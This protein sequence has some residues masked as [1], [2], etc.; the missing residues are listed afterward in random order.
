MGP[1]NSHDGLSGKR[2]LVTGGAGFLGSA[3]VRELCHAGAEVTVLDNFS[4]GK[5]EYLENLTQT[6]GLKILAGDICDQGMVEKSMRD[7]ELVIHL[8]ALPFIPDSYHHPKDFFRTNVEG[9]INLLL[10]AS[11]AGTVERFVYISSSEVYGSAKSE[12]MNEDHPTLPPSTYAA[13]K[14]AADRVTF[15]MSKEGA[16]P[17]VIVRPFNCFGPN[18]TQPYIVPEI[19]GQ[20]SNGK[21][22]LWLGNVEACRDLTFVDDTARGIVLSAVAPRTV[23]EIINLGSGSAISIRELARKILSLMGKRVEI[24]KDSSRMRP[25]DVERL[26]C[27]NSKAKKILSWKPMIALEEGLRRTIDWVRGN[28]VHFQSPFE[29][30]YRTNRVTPIITPQK[31][32]N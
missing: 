16:V 6:N 9:T 12:P 30:W 1:S 2:I 20:A 15:T 21:G 31:A 8:A 29:N 7:A 32:K 14:L 4:S 18:I 23:G 17:A 13:S 25:Y 28:S 11:K 5:R 27:D 10:A 26:I 24:R 22:E 19:I 3:V